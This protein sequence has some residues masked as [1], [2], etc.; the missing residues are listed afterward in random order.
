[1]FYLFSK[2]KLQNLKAQKS[3]SIGEVPKVSC[4]FNLCLKW[5]CFFLFSCVVLV[6]FF[7]TIIYYLDQVDFSF[8]DL[9]VVVA[10]MVMMVVAMVVMVM[11]KA[12]MVI[13]MIVIIMRY[14]IFLLLLL[15]FITLVMFFAYYFHGLGHIFL[16]YVL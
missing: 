8:G 2:L 6:V 16:C 14:I 5:S 10:I 11:A 4:S 13:M 7:V 9:C 15:L 1:M 12:V 3:S